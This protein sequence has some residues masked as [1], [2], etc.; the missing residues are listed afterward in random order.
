MK[1]RSL[2]NGLIIIIASVIIAS[3]G[4]KGNECKTNADCPSGEICIAGSC[5]SPEKCSKDSDCESG[6]V[7][8]NNICIP[9]E[10]GKCNTDSDCPPNY[11]CE[12][13]KCMIKPVQGCTSDNDCPSG[14]V[15][16]NGI[17]VTPQDTTPPETTLTSYPRNPTNS[18]LATFEFICNEEPCTFECLLDNGE[19]T[20]CAS[21]KIYTELSEGYHVFSVYARD[22]AGNTLKLTH[23][24]N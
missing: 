23:I 4:K 10:A 6:Y 14:Q 24:F 15:C 1:K 21:P 18:T 11:A 7:C 13:K 3:C 17:C 9:K 20:L 19:W 12:N 8:L 5:E 16:E 22:S 2:V